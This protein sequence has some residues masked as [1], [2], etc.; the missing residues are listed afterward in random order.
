MRMTT[1]IFV[2]LMVLGPVAAMAAPQ[3][4]LT[5]AEERDA[6]RDAAKAMPPGGAVKVELRRGGRVKGTLVAVTDDSVVLKTAA[7]KPALEVAFADVERIER[8]D[9]KG[10]S[11]ARAIGVGAGAGAGVF[12]TLMAVALMALYN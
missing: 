3:R 4:P 6:W 8:D 2:M 11:I 12:V 10:W 7:Q 1:S 5:S 9:K